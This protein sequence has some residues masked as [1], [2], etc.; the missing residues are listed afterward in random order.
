MLL[1]DSGRFTSALKKGAPTSS[2]P[3]KQGEK[4]VSEVLVRL[5]FLIVFLTVGYFCA[6]GL[7]EFHDS[8][9]KAAGCFFSLVICIR[10]VFVALED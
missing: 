4:T 9:H 3:V 2:V 10:F 5:L 7:I 8:P 1:I 6:W